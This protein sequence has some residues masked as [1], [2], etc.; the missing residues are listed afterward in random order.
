MTPSDPHAGAHAHGG[1]PHNPAVAHETSDVNLRSILMFA[2]GIA[3][4]GI[5]SG[6]LVLGVFDFFERQ[7]VARDPLVSPLAVPATTMPRSTTGSPYFGGA[8]QPQL[9]TSEPTVL[10]QLR[11][12]E[13]TQL[14]GYGW[15]DQKGGVARI[16]IDEAKKKLIEHG[17][18]ARSGSV[19][20]RLGTHAQAYG[21]ASGGRTIPTGGGTADAADSSAAG[22]EKPQQ[23]ASPAPGIH[24][25]G[26]QGHH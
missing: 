19:D 2:A 18:P 13:D 11:Q 8:P 1:E 15:V 7:A 23:P 4:V 25:E 16:P 24:K 10:R 14:D 17:L 6:G 26:Q 21:E 22:K 5:V 9:L 20:P 12:N 3:V